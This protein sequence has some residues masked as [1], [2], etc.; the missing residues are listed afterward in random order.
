M[1]A[2]VKPCD[3]EQSI[4]MHIIM[5]ALVLVCCMAASP[6]VHAVAAGPNRA[7]LQTIYLLGWLPY[8]M[9]AGPLRAVN[10]FLRIF[11]GTASAA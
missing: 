7:R 3:R 10:N 5:V 9:I 4:R 11:E 8:G 1:G 2:S 6:P